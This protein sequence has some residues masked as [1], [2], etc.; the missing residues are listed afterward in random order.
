LQAQK[1]IYDAFRPTAGLSCSLL[2]DR[3]VARRD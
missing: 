1:K 2:R 3:L